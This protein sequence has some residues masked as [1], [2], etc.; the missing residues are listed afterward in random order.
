MSY[1]DVTYPVQRLL[2]DAERPFKVSHLKYL[3]ATTNERNVGISDLFRNISYHLKKNDWIVVF[4]ALALIHLL[5][6]EGNSER[7]L[8]FLAG[9]LQLLDMQYYR[10]TLKHP[11]GSLQEQNIRNYGYYLHEKASVY[12]LTKRDWNSQR[13]ECV[14]VIKSMTIDVDILRESELLQRTIDACVSCDWQEG[15]LDHVVVRQAYRFI[16]ADLM[17]LFHIMNETIIALLSM[18]FTMPHSN[19]TRGLII[20][21]KFCIQAKKAVEMF[22]TGRRINSVLQ[23]DIPKF[24]HPATTLTVSLEKYLNAPDFESQRKLY[25]AKNGTVIEPSIP[26]VPS[27]SKPNQKQAPLIDFFSSIDDEQHSNTNQTHQAPD[28]FWDEN[29]AFNQKLNGFTPSNPFADTNLLQQNLEKQ[30][31]E[32]NLM[33]N[34]ASSSM[35]PSGSNSFVPSNTQQSTIDRPF[36]RANASQSFGTAFAPK[37]H[38]PGSAFASKTYD[39]ASAFAPKTQAFDPSSA[40][41]P[42]SQAYDPFSQQ[43][44]NAGQISPASNASSSYNPFAASSQSGVSQTSG[45]QGHISNAMQGNQYSN[46]FGNGNAQLFNGQGNAFQPDNGNAQFGHVNAI[47]SN[48]GKTQSMNRTANAFLPNNGDVF[49]A[50]PQPFNPFQPVI[51]AQM[52]RSNEQPNNAFSDV[53]QRKANPHN[54]FV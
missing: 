12:R 15:E 43:G 20:Y 51:N 40:F 3:I 10:N 6:R 25:A 5:I 24:T 22:E 45:F 47:P 41:S 2:T 53:A 37:T 42:K 1:E 32:T 50:H 34:A 9:N 35:Y 13:E 21:K 19:A 7:V 46:T 16:I 14:A 33:L 30:L 18:Y 26:N 31:M 44:F 8:G 54:P 52:P 27:S 38:D 29:D 4:K 49:M 28:P 11:M 48:N 17:G 23:L 36:H 39:P